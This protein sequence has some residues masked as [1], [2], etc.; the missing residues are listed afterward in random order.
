[1]P[2]IGWLTTYQRAWLRDDLVSGVVV[3]AIMNPAAMACAQMAGVETADILRDLC[4]DLRARQ[5]DLIFAQI[6]GS[7]HD[8]MTKTGLLA[9][10]GEDHLFS[11]IAAAVIAFQ[12]RPAPAEALSALLSE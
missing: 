7:V 3:G 8:R 11:S 4:S 12:A 10:L 5:I 2:L 6:K 9:H 1:V